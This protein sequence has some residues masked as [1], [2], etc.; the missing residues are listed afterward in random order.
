MKKF[1]VFLVIV[2]LL[3]I[4]AASAEYKTPGDDVLEYVS[5]LGYYVSTHDFGFDT[6]ICSL[7]ET[8]DS[9]LL[10]FATNGKLSNIKVTVDDQW[11]NYQDLRALFYEI[12]SR[13]QWDRSSFTPE[14]DGECLIPVS[15]GLLE[16]GRPRVDYPDYDEYLQALQHALQ[17]T[18]APAGVVRQSDSYKRMKETME[19]TNTDN[20]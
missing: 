14:D 7:I 5:S 2:C 8:D 17:S 13:W 15:Y 20:P 6:N 18:P 4:T 12:S 10:S 19:G 1:F 3:A 9:Q 11:T 16:N